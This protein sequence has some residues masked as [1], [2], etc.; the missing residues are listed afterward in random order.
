M[1]KYVRS[2]RSP[3]KCKY[4]DKEVVIVFTD[5]FILFSTTYLMR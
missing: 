3:E 2:L 5:K 1:F 4:V